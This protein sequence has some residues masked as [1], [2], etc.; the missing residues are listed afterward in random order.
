MITILATGIEE[1][2][3]DSIL[4]MVLNGFKGDLLDFSYLKFDKIIK[5]LI[6][7]QKI[8]NLNSLKIE[9]FKK[10]Q[11]SV[12]SEMERVLQREMKRNANIIINTGL[13]LKTVRG[14]FPLLTPEIF[15]T[16]KPDI[17]MLFEIATDKDHISYIIQKEKYDME[18]V[19]DR[20]IINKRYALN[21][22]S[23]L[24]CL[25]KVIKIE[26]GNLRAAIKETKDFIE[27]VMRK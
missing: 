24:G 11:S 15:N 5:N 4:D 10:L 3:K 23:S 27:Y 19:L 13:V 17:I 22:S 9:E 26:F 21:Y 2:G 20:Q 12:N 7:K 8:T 25:L 16:A 18:D 1:S 14:Y 6:L